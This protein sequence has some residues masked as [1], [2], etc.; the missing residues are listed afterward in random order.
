MIFSFSYFIDCFKRPRLLVYTAFSEGVYFF[1]QYAPEEFLQ[2]DA[3]MFFW[4]GN[5]DRALAVYIVCSSKEKKCNQVSY[6]LYGVRRTYSPQL[7]QSGAG[8]LVSV[9]EI[10]S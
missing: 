3:K 2:D 7:L 5:I 1:P 10:A 9:S 8:A 6:L 4:A